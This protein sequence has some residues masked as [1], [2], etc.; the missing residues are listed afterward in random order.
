MARKPDDT[1]GPELLDAELLA[2]AL[3]H[4]L[5]Q[6]LMGADA[7]AMLLE[8]AAGAELSRHPEWELLRRQLGRLVEVL[9]NYDDLFRAG[10]ARPVPFAAGPVVTRAVE[11]LAHRT[12]PLGDRFAF[13]REPGRLDAFGSPGALIHATTN[14]IS[15]A[16]DAVEAAPGGGRVEVRVLRAAS[17][18]EVRVSDQGVGIPAEH[19]A[20]IFEARFTTKAPGRGIGLGLHLSRQLMTRFGG[21][22]LLVEADDPRRLPGAVTELCIVVPSPPPAGGLP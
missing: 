11:L 1:A 18:V 14:L 9:T 20:R 21:G 8:R 17:G 3:L 12:R 2:P 10:D 13:T 6:P 4:E 5:K 16:I 19:R 22:L 15:N 7:A